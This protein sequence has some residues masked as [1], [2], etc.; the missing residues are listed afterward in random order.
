METPKGY[1][2]EPRGH[3]P[4]L[5]CSQANILINDNGHA[6]LTE[7][8]LLMMVP[9]QST[10]AS[11]HMDGGTTRWMSPELLDPK[12]FGLREGQRT[13]ESDCYALGMVIYEILSGQAPFAPLRPFEVILRVM[14]GL[15]PE[16]PKG[17]A[18][19]LFTDDIWRTLELCWKQR[20]SERISAKVVL[21]RLEKSSPLPQ[22]RF[23]T[24]GTVDTSIEVS[25]NP[26]LRW[27]VILTLSQTEKKR[28]G[29]WHKKEDKEAR[30]LKE[31]LEVHCCS[32][33]F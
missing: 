13:K 25:C 27:D 20:P 26:Y 17:E 28:K 33:V 29:L 4:S 10:D 30:E 2:S 8:G 31:E 32:R 15:R 14:K 21:Q 22:P 9:D 5:S 23:N 16:R 6:C 3:P 7:F 12:G 1:V 11:P 24:D 18:G 19:V